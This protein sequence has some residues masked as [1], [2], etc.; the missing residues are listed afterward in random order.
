MMAEKQSEHPLAKAVVNKI[1]HLIP[2]K[3]EEFSQRYQLVEFKNRDGE[4]IHALIR[5]KSQEGA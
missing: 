4:G 3:I 2:S 1:G 5:D